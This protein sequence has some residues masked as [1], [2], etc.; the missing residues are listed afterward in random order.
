MSATLSASTLLAVPM[1]PLV[2]AVL[3][4]LFG[5]KFGGNHIGRKVT[6][7]LT[8][9]GVAIA[10]ILS[11]MT[12]KSVVVDGARF[13]ATL[14]EWMIV[15]GLKMEVGFLVDGLTAMM[16]CV[17]TFVS[18]MVHIYTI[19]YMEEDEG[20]NRFFSYISLFT[21]SMLMLVM[22]NNMLQLFFGWEAVGLVS[23]L[24]IGFWYNKP[25]AIFA[26][27]KAFLVNRVGDFGFILGIGLIAAYAGTLNYGEAFA[28]ADDL[29]KLTFP[30]TEWMLVTVICICLFI[31]AMGKS[32][33]F[34]LHV[35]LPDSMEG[36][37][38]I[39]A[40]IHAATMVTAGIFMVARMSPLF[41][42]SDTALSFIL[43]IGSITALFMGF[44][45]IIQNDIKRVVAYST[46]SQLGYMTVALGA[47]AYSVAVFHLMTHA[48]F[49]AL[50]FLG[51][52][53]VIIGMHHNQDIR[54]MGGVRKY[55]PITWITS[56]LGSLAL[57]GTPLFSGFYS[58]DSIIEAVH[59]SHLWGAGFANF[60]VLAGV[61][62]T[63][64]YS[65]RMYFLVFHG[66]ERYDQNPD[67]HH[68]DHHGH[69]DHGHGQDA[70]KPHESPWVVWLPLVL[71][72][73]PSVVIGYFTIQ[74]MLYGDF[75]KDAIFFNLDKH[76]AMRELAEAFHGP[77][78]MAVHG[79]TTMPFWLALA[80][81]VSSYVMYMMYPAIPT[82][83][84]RACGPI[85]RLLENKYYLDW[86]NENI[87][88]RG[89]R[90]LG[91]AFWKGG[92]QAL[93]DGAIVNGS[94]K[95]IG[96]ISAAVRWIQS[97][98]IYHYAFAM[99][100]G[101]FVLMTYFVWFNK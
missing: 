63:A 57:I 39:S 89:A 45:G 84:K 50:L 72:A 30:G 9:L 99:L 52:G 35:W 23:Y 18:L 28:K 71:L 100:L 38:P 60:A 64:F 56:L 55:M 51:A 69:D 16:M 33:Q 59:E 82:A 37:T 85:Y 61:F 15:G 48:F 8:I 81:V 80:G 36:P 95:T 54:W 1:A 14:Y 26:N 21:F 98:Y 53:S 77:W 20:Y 12:L 58:K 44:L 92:D 94:W 41:E 93:I 19:G 96:R 10:F 67:A 3:A 86:I 79:L 2:G 65:F 74:P 5:T 90:A 22:S 101:V 24:L 7:S 88:A 25:T 47:S 42:L 70:H 17:V 13:N 66:K 97:G 91:T 78:A 32:A 76:H 29:A 75:F 62:V 6:H 40:L 34:P 73:I 68:D 49:K 87:V 46:L 27:M 31:G 43:V 4:G 83:I 11:A